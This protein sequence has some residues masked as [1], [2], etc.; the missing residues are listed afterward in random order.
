MPK[1]SIHSCRGDKYAKG[2]CKEHY[3]IFLAETKQRDDETNRKKA[4]M[5]KEILQDVD[6][7]R[8]KLNC[9]WCGRSIPGTLDYYY[10]HGNGCPTC[11]RKAEKRA[12]RIDFNT[13]MI[14]RL[15]L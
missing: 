4:E 5:E 11:N 6:V 14:D 8:I 13:D 9:S 10:E 2:L 12:S 15:Q 7:S 3:D 1:C